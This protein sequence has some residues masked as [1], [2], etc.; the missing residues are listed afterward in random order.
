MG[1]KEDNNHNLRMFS[2]DCHLSSLFWRTGI[3]TR[4]CCLLDEHQ[5]SAKATAHRSH[6]SLPYQLWNRLQ[7]IWC[8]EIH[9]FNSSLAASPS[10]MYWLNSTRRRG[11][12]YRLHALST[13]WGASDV[14]N[15][16]AG[17]QDEAHLALADDGDLQLLHSGGWRRERLL[18]EWAQLP[19]KK[20]CLNACMLTTSPDMASYSYI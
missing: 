8:Y 1:V 3:R 14:V 13:K 19:E 6:S 4:V 17:V 16:A 20:T 11:L 7:E 10:N 18:V 2:R 5:T 12:I 15:L 9:P